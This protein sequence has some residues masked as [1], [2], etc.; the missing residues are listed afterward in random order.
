MASTPETMDAPP[1]L[2]FP[3]APEARLRLALRQLDAALAEQ[4]EAV[5]LFRR[6]I[7]ELRNAV[8]G[9]EEQAEGYRQV[10]H[11]VAA[12]TADAHAAALRLMG[13]ADAM[14]ARA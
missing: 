4:S 5:A 8:A 1:V 2:V 13:T 3:Q 12:E 11:G 9:L 10:L 14:L 7:S 6:E